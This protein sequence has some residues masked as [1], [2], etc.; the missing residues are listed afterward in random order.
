MLPGRGFALSLPVQAGPGDPGLGDDLG[1]GVAGL[2][3]VRGVGQLVRFD[4]RR[5][6]DALALR[7]GHCAGAGGALEDDGQDGGELA[8]DGRDGPRR[9]SRGEQELVL[10]AAA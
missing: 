9:T 3:Q 2:A 1:H 4:H 10:A 6:P 7:C 8:G 5:P